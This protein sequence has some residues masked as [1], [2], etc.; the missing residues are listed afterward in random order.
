[1]RVKRYV[2]WLYVAPASLFVGVYLVWPTFQTIVLSVFGPH[3]ALFVGLDNFVQLFTQGETWIAARNNIVW[4]LALPAFAVTFGAA[5]ALLFERVRYETLAKSSVFLPMVISFVGAGVIWKFVYAYMPE[6]YPQIGILNAIRA[7]LGMDPLAWMMQRPVLNNLLLVVVAAWGWTGFCLIVISAAYKSMDREMIDAAR[8]D[9]ANEWQV[10]RYVVLPQIKSALVGVTTL[11]M[12][13]SLKTFDV[14]YVMTG[15]NY[16][17]DV[18]AHRMYRE[19]FRFHDSGV[20]SAL[21]VL[22]L[23]AA[24]PLV[25]MML[26]RFGREGRTLD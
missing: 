11:M 22:L 10:V 3:G 19:M 4:M 8:L 16:G 26:S 18:L 21:A 14:V 9:G 12:V 1:M 5:F 2:P 6:I 25:G 20:A 24:L 23:L 13:I 7:A 15:G 17:T